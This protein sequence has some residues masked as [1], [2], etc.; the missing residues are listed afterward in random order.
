MTAVS[1][2]IEHLAT[3]MEFFTANL[4]QT[5]ARNNSE[6]LFLSPFSIATVLSMVYLGSRSN[7]AKQLENI[8]NAFSFQDKIHMAFQ[9]YMNILQSE[10]K[11]FTLK[12][13]NRIYAN[14]KLLV[15]ND[16][17]TELTKY[18]LSTIESVD[19]NKK[20]AQ[21]KDAI[22]Q[23]VEA[24]TNGKIRNLIPDNALT[25]E[26]LLVLINA[27]YF[28]GKWAEKFP[29][30]ATS[31]REFF[32][33]VGK[34]IEHDM[35]YISDKFFIKMDANLGCKI[36][37]LPYVGNS[38]SMF[39]V[40]PDEIDGLSALEQKLNPG[41]FHSLTERNGFRKS[42]V[43]VFLPKFSLETRFE[44]KDILANMGL[45][46]LFDEEKSDLSGMVSDNKR[47]YVSKVI[48]KA[49]VEVNEEGTEAAAA[50]AGLVMC[51]LSLEMGIEFKA[52][53]PFMFSIIDKR[54]KAVLFVGRVTN[55]QVKA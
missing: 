4:Y 22:N 20:A 23:W 25:P 6:N 13:A 40:L 29:K 16:Y 30:E 19:F 46:D 24:Y 47:L 51:A 43:E 39:V 11:N 2:N 52:D 44:L 54:S 3:S 50:T 35:M 12:S 21:T 14:Q 37:E 9:E 55:P 42:E 32:L 7:T 8:L 33:S 49:F 10:S 31:K 48:H 38:L 1:K 53:H 18:Y 45:T 34:Q 28:K 36:L 41:F 27:I 17:K 26:T 15:S 5:V